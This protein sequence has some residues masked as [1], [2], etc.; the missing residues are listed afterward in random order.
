MSAA[1]FSTLSVWR[2]RYGAARDEADLT[3]LPNRISDARTS[4]I[5]R[6]R[7]LA[8]LDVLPSET[9]RCD[10]QKA[11]RGLR[12]MEV[13][14]L[15]YVKV[16]KEAKAP[17]A[18]AG[19]GSIIRV[20]FKCPKC[21]QGMGIRVGLTVTNGTRPVECIGCGRKLIPL[22]HGPIVEGPYAV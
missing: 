18:A 22:V 10:I 6:Y 4:I 13:T 17:K 21:G 3:E 7:E 12:E 2:R 20:R 19:A 16:E 15:G 11:V 14:R 9:E 8:A 5:A 1:V